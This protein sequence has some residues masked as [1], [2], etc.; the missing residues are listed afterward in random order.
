MTSKTSS[1]LS[2]LR[3]LSG[4][5]QMIEKRECR[6]T[7]NTFQF[8]LQFIWMAV[9]YVQLRK[10]RKN[11]RCLRVFCTITRTTRAW[12][13]P[14][15]K[16]PQALARLPGKRLCVCLYDKISFF[17]MTKNIGSSCSWVIISSRRM[18]RIFLQNLRLF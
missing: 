4:R 1:S 14:L 8:L 3:S 15:E 12:S 6:V 11:G 7:T 13:F 5:Y 10:K 9:C 18:Y 16:L 17:P 2:S